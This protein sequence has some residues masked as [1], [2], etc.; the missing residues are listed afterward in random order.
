MIDFGPQIA[1]VD[2][3]KNE[4]QGI[5]DYL[6][7]HNIGCKYFNADITEDNS[8]EFPLESVEL[9]FLD[10]YYTKDFDPV[11]CAQ[12]IDDIIPDK[13][14]YELVVWSKDSHLTDALLE[15]LF[16]IGK[17]P[18]Y[19]ITK[20]K[21]KYDDINGIERLLK[22]IKEE[23]KSINKIKVDDF[24]SE[25]IEITEDHV[26]L[27]CLL[28]DEINFFQ[29]RK[30]EKTP[31]SHFKKFEEGAYLLV[32]ITTSV[33]QRNIEFIELFDDHS[34]IFEQK[35]IFLKFKG[36]PIQNPKGND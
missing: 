2:D 3:N 22:E 24:I 33:G 17:L 13:K 28:D 6:E 36:T 27:N 14:L 34:G 12:W 30:F 4:I 16:Q 32:R 21:N 10:L 31:L 1:I 9:I 8:P 15:V 35:N 5:L 7:S 20:Q 26:V 25:I 29:I 18:R 23:V 19:C 11:R